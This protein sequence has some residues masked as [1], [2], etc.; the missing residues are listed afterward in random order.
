MQSGLAFGFSTPV[1]A[2]L[3]RERMDEAA[4]I[5]ARAVREGHVAAAVLHVVQR[6]FSFTR[7][8]RK[9]AGE[10]AMFL[11]GSI[12]KPISITALMTLFDQGEFNLRR[13]NVPAGASPATTSSRSR[14]KRHRRFRPV[15]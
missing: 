11:L 6:E 9:A 5:L 13:P 1:L 12:S 7:S 2:A 15:G 14:R 10:N 4:A 3:V 8:F